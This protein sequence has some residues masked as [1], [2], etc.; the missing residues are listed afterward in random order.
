M[1]LDSANR[2][3]RRL[4]IRQRPVDCES[5]ID[6]SPEVFPQLRLCGSWQEI[7][8][9]IRSADIVGFLD[10]QRRGGYIVVKLLPRR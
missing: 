8:P 3:S 6:I 2:A 10:N 1:V 7:E 5:R 4:D 9:E